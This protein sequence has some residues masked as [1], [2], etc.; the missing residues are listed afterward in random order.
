MAT[1]HNWQLGRDM[2]YPYESRRPDRQF[3]MVFDTNKCIACQTCTVACKT[4]WKIGRASCRER[5]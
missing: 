2:E 4:T 1:V 3:A 5:V